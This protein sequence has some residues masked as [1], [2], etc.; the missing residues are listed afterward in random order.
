MLTLDT[1]GLLAVLDRQDAY[2]APCADVFEADPGPFL[3]S[4]AVL[5][6][7]AWLLEVRFPPSVEDRVLQNIRDGALSL[8]WHAH[9]VE[10]I[11]ELIRKYHDLPLGVADAAVVACAERRGGR[12]LTTDFRHFPIV[13]R[14]ERGLTLLP[15]PYS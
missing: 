13:A 15:E 14:G 1:S 11:Q 10:R 8:D 7:I 4:T 2:H 3:I 12:I 5:S 9:D 6:E